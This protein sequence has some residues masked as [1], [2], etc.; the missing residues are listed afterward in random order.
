MGITLMALIGLYIAVGSGLPQVRERFEMNEMQFFNAW[1]LKSLMLLLIV[2][3]ATVTLKRIPFTPPRWGVWCIHAGIITLIL[4][5]GFYYHFKT[6]GMTRI[7]VGRSADFYYDAGMRSL[8]A[9]TGIDLAYP[10]DL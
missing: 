5:T 8:Y 6:E 2:N 10:Y 3:L 4:G 7:P 1:P 9:R